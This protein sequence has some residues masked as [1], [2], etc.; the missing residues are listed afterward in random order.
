MSGAPVHLDERE[1]ACPVRGANVG[2]IFQFFQLLPTLTVSRTSCCRWTSG[3]LPGQTPRE[4]F[5]LACAGGAGNARRPPA[6]RAIRR[7]AAA[8]GGKPARLANDPPIIIADEPYGQPRYHHRRRVHNPP[9]RSEPGGKSV[10][11]VTHDPVLALDARKGSSKCRTAG[12]SP[13]IPPVNDRQ[14]G[15]PGALPITHR[16][17]LH[18]RETRHCSPNVA[19]T[20]DL[21]RFL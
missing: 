11:F 8:G 9:A 7:R 14:A 2:I 16:L 6:K 4:G 3:R 12:S 18:N 15:L 21:Y 20:P 5:A 19:A 13:T 1:R 17:P 10:I